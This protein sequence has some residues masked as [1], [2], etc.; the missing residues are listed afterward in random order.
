MDA[1]GDGAGRGHGTGR[2]VEVF[3]DVTCPFAHVSLRRFVEQRRRAGADGVH[4]RVRAWPL[5][6]VNGE[7]LGAEKVAEEIVDLRSQVAA[8]LFDGFDPGAWPS[9]T[10]GPLAVATSAYAQG[11]GVGEAVNLALRD[12]LFELGRPIADPEVLAAIAAEHG[13]EVPDPATAEAVVATD[14]TDGRRRGVIGSPHF[15]LGDGS[16]FCPG[17]DISKQGGHLRIDVRESHFREFLDRA[18]A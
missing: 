14:L 2:V 4:L 7:P 8:D 11:V 12:A 9:T 15:F 17:L 1:V 10:I 3:A 5:E 6:L 16:F 13:V 18:F